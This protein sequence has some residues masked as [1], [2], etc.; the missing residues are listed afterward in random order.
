MRD[1]LYDLKRTLSGRFTI[2]MMALIVIATVG[3]AYASVSINSG[4]SS[5]NPGSTA[6]VLP[7]V[8]NDNGTYRIVDYAVNGYG[9]PVPDLH[10]VTYLSNGTFGFQ[11]STNP[12]PKLYVNGTTDSKGFFNTTF[13]AK[14]FTIYEYSQEYL[15]GVNVTSSFITVYNL[16][17]GRFA[18]TFADST[19]SNEET[20]GSF[21]Y[22]MAVANVSNKLEDNLLIYYSSASGKPMPD[23]GIYYFLPSSSY[24]TTI[25]KSNMT[26]LKTVGG[27]YRDE[28]KLPLN[29]TANNAYITVELFSSSGQEN[30]GYSGVLYRSSAASSIIEGFL[31]FPYEFLIPILGIF[32]AYFYYGKDKASGVLESIIS[33]PVTKGRILISRFLGGSL[34][35][36][37]A[38]FIS[39][40]LADLVV[41][42]YTGSSLSTSSFV[43]ILLGYTVEAIG[44]A[45][46]VYLISQ[47]VKSQGGIL[48]ISIGLFFV[49]VIFWNILM[50]I[51]LFETHVNL[52]VKSGVI[53]TIILN[54][55]SPAYYP[56][57]ILD[58]HTGIYGSVLGL[59]SGITASSVG[60]TLTA[61]LAVGIFWVVVPSLASF[62]LARS[63]D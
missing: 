60:I 42:K 4:S 61:V 48:G 33:K 19:L 16:S 46:I 15:S 59:T 25:P 43:S 63:R 2:I 37:A 10:L 45:G 12:G 28:I 52:A 58:Y 44:F 47:F 56:T 55:I 26:Y 24:Q 39:L 9:N 35:F 34:S 32:S 31:Q 13:T 3:I 49:M 57:L 50:D 11:A 53:D 38:L 40:A 20:N 7:S 30:I 14:N 6:Y 36:L 41:L 5:V 23:Q 21:Y 54:S 17:I 1:F 8:Y 18:A 62:F 27:V 51:I 22:I 29:K